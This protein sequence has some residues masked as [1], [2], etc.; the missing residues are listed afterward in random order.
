MYISA[1]IKAWGRMFK[2]YILIGIDFST[3]YDILITLSASS[4]RKEVET[5][6]NIIA[7]VMSVMADIVGLSLQVVR[8]T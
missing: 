1:L 8:Q 7:F 2:I 4:A 5:L 3:K 6:E